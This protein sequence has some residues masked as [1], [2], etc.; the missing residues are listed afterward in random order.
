MKRFLSC[1][2]VALACHVQG[3]FVTVEPVAIDKPVF[4][5][6]MGVYHFSVP[7]NLPQDHWSREICSVV[8]FRWDWSKL[9][10]EK[11][12]YKFDEIIGQ[13]Y[14]HWYVKQGIPIAFRVMSQSRHSP[15][16]YVTPKFVFDSG[17]P[18]VE[19]VALNGKTQY[20]PVFWD[21]RY[22]AALDEFHAALGKWLA[23][24]KE[25]I[26]FMDIGGIGEWGEMH[27]QR[28]TP[29]QFADTGY[30]HTRYVMAYRSMIDSYKRH[31]GG[32]RIFLNVGGQN[33]HTIN[34]YA[35]INGMHFRQDGLKHTG[36]SYNCGEW[37]YKPYAEKG[38]LCNYEFH[39]S[40][41]AMQARGWSLPGSIDV[42]LREPISYLNS[43]LGI[44][45][46]DV[47][48]EIKDELL[49]CAKRIGYRLRPTRV[50]YFEAMT[51]GIE[52]T[53]PVVSTW[54]NDG[55]ARPS[56]SF[57]IRWSLYDERGKKVAETLN[58][59][60][61]P[62]TMWSP[63]QSQEVVG[64]LRL[65]AG[66]E[67]GVYQLKVQMVIPETRKAI[68]LAI[69]GRDNR[70]CYAIGRVRLA[71]AT[72]RLPRTVF[73]QEFDKKSDLWQP[74]KA[75]T[76]QVS[77]RKGENGR[78]WMHITGAK[79]DKLWNYVH[80]NYDGKVRPWC[81]Y[82]LSMKVK[83]AE[84]STLN[85]G[86]HPKIALNDENGKWLGNINGSS[87]DLRKKGTWQELEVVARLGGDAR[88]LTFALE[89]G[90]YA[91]IVDNVD[92]SIADVKLELIH[93]P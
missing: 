6:G 35:F 54:V 12:V 40:Y 46:K 59:P 80:R 48:Q 86:C 50:Q 39:A 72:H 37:L 49:R 4:N 32:I 67:S 34:D 42:V 25:G 56:M 9:N 20:D 47:P 23:D 87:Y 27:L 26:E 41:K 15:L 66:L 75:E 51:C 81:G 24:K 88:T 21:K 65:P 29:Q 52:K 43:N 68:N 11:G 30:S 5:P 1:L 71:K 76:L 92:I 82:R 77:L 58:F 33:N 83:V 93:E 10:P 55:I 36:A 44:Y 84:T 89:T 73:K 79:K 31:F 3:Q 61:V 45:D 19:H 38:A 70:G 60:E 90:D 8:Y 14:D 28:W 16:Q 91:G 74:T 62:T 69:E 7:S 85:R 64:E 17:V 2:L 63:G 22:L 13:M 18:Y 53:V 78:S 57:G